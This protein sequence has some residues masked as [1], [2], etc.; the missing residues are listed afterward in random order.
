MMADWL[1]DEIWS[2]QW[3]QFG[4][5]ARGRRDLATRLAMVRAIAGAMAAQGVRADR[6][7]AEALLVIDVITHSE[8]WYPVA[9]A[10]E[11]P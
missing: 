11:E 4:S 2:L 3:T 8:H 6:A 10:L 9:Q 1:A 5:F 7:T